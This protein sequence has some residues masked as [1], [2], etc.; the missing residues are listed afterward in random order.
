VRRVGVLASVLV[1]AAVAAAL[2]VAASPDDSVNLAVVGVEARIGDD[3]VQ[4]SGV[5]IDADDGLVLTT[6]HTIWGATELRLAT[7]VGMLHGRIV[8]RAPCTDLALLETQPRI[9]GL[10]ALSGSPA[11]IDHPLDVAARGPD[12]ALARLH[13]PLPEWTSG[14]PVL[15]EKGHVTGI[16]SAARGRRSWVVPWSLVSERLDELRPGPRRIFVG[17]RDH[18]ACAPFL[19]TFAQA[20]HPAFREADAVLN[21]P[22]PATRVPGTEE[23]DR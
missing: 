7:H 13:R 16:V 5:V 12:G 20:R 19:H 2:A 22:V 9:P 8:A 4:S 21:A 23:L 15:E 6:A 14:A 10:V 1:V 3:L 11:A 18:Y 17:W